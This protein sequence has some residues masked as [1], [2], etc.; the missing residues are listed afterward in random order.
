MSLLFLWGPGCTCLHPVM[1]LLPSMS[2]CALGLRSNDA[3]STKHFLNF[4]LDSPFRPV[5]TLCVWR[6]LHLALSS[7]LWFLYI[8]L[9]FTSG[10]RPFGGQRPLCIHV[11][12]DYIPGPGPSGMLSCLLRTCQW[13]MLNLKRFYE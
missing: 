6:D 13:Q 9:S 2:G 1:C 10:L 5:C 7:L 4:S 3:F 11:F 8:S 12:L